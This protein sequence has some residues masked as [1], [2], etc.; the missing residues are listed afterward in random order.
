[1]SLSASELGGLQFTEKD[2]EDFS[3]H[4]ERIRYFHENPNQAMGL[5]NFNAA[6]G[7]IDNLQQIDKQSEI[8]NLDEQQ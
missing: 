1:V 8:N 3:R 4:L 7:N 2:L 6:L 5:R